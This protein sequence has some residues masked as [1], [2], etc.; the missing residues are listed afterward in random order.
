MQTRYLPQK[1]GSTMK[2]VG[3]FNGICFLMSTTMA[4]FSVAISLLVQRD[5]SI[6][7]L[8]GVMHKHDTTEDPKA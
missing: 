7:L 4:L 2:I 6:Q 3:Y 1:D 8:P 5:D